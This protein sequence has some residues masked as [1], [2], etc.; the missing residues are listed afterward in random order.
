MIVSC[1]MGKS[2]DKKKLEKIDSLLP[3]ITGEVMIGHEGLGIPI[4]TAGYLYKS[5]RICLV[6][7]RQGG[8]RFLLV[9]GRGRHGWLVGVGIGIFV[10]IIREAIIGAGVSKEKTSGATGELY[11]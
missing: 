3:F 10:F 6:G 4:R 7:G 1:S 9:S 8:C 11:D 2:R 5:S